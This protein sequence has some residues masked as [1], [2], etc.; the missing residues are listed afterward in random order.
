MKSFTLLSSV[1]LLLFTVEIQAQNQYKYGKIDMSE[2]EMKIY[3]KDSSAKAVV[4]YEDGFTRYDYRDGFFLT[5]EVKCR[6]KILKPEGAEKATIYIPI[7]KSGRVEESLSGIEG[8]AYNLENGKIVKTKLEKTN[9]FE[10]KVTDNRYTTKLAIPGAKEGS[11]IEYKYTLNSPFYQDISDWYFQRD[12]P[13]QQ[14]KYELKIPEYFIYKKN[15]KGFESIQAIEKDDNQAILVGS[16]SINAKAKDYIFSVTDMPALVGDDY[17]WEVSDFL[18]GVHLELSATNFPG[19]FSRPFNSDWSSI[20][21]TIKESDFLKYTQ[22]SVP[23]KE[24]LGKIATISN[25][26]D[27][28]SAVYNL[29]KSK[30][31]WNGKYTFMDNPSDAFKTGTGNNA[32]INSAL[33]SALNQVGIKSYAVLM[34]RRSQGRLPFAIASLDKITTFIVAAELSDTTTHYMDASAKF[35]SVDLLPTEMSVDHAR[36]FNPNGGND[37]VDLTKVAKNIIS[38]INIAHLSDDGNLNVKSVK[39]FK[40]QPAYRYKL[41]YA[42]AKDSAE[43]IEKFETNNKIKLQNVAITGQTDRFGNTVKEEIEF[44]S[45]ANKRGNFIYINPLIIPQMTTNNFT[46]SER[47]LPVEFS[48][49]YSYQITSTIFIPAGYAVEE[50]PKSTKLVLENQGGSLSYNVRQQDNTIQINYRFQLNQVIFPYMSYPM[51]RD[52]FGMT[53]TKNTEMIVLKKL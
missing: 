33:I 2:L 50:L 14:S 4:L 28:L 53:V 19:D 22:K 47:K 6:I 44:T 17:V 8:Y 45:Q 10:E 31:S 9:I 49:P 15:M 5:T 34:R 18:T 37:F 26:N 16:Q 12:I 32:Q 39:Y 27:K 23:W 24:E 48:Y 3:P 13:V 7:Y 21:K 40:M 29:V 46:Q 36:T 30:I 38:V 25:E 52:F 11:V 35:G 1:L 51:L 43:F 41:D 20:E 42:A